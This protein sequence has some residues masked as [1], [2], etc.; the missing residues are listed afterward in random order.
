MKLI[1]DFFPLVL[2]FGAYKWQG[3]F[4]ATAVAIAA[5]ILQVA[6]HWWRQRRF[7]TSQLAM[8]G[9]ITVFGGATLLFQDDTF[10]KWKPTVLNWLF[11]AVFLG[12]QYIGRK[13]IS[14]RMMGATLSLPQIIWLR[15]NI[16]WVVFFVFL[17]CLNLYVAHR[18][19]TDTW[20]DF[21]VFGMF[22]LTLVFLVGQMIYLS[23]HIKE[24]PESPS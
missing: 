1:F 9:V 14:E 10:I 13:N 21:K 3:I 4:V 15:I 16:S 8:L 5:S 20:V 23:R 2:F 19:D 11:A 22:G 17:G 12:S 7:E 6:I 24:E 18:Y